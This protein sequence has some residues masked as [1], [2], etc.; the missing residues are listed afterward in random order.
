MNNAGKKILLA[1]DHELIREGLKRIF[2]PA[3]FMAAFG[4]RPP[5]EA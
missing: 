5:R 4:L 1:D 3:V 2:L